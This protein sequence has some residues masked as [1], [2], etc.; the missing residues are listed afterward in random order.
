M[1]DWKGLKEQI[2]T[3]WDDK[4]RDELARLENDLIDNYLESQWQ[5][6]NEKI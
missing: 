6:E 4:K 1:I 5:K 3:E 2:E